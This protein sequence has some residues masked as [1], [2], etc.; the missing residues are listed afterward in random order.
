MTIDRLTDL[1][2]MWIVYHYGAV[3]SLRPDSPTAVDR[4]FD[5]SIPLASRANGTFQDI[6]DIERCEE[7]DSVCLNE[8]VY[9]IYKTRSD[10]IFIGNESNKLPARRAN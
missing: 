9:S 7:V 8:H 2:S 6:E 3:L 4:Y 5:K 10:A 1:P